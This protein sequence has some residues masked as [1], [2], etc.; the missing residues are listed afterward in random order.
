MFRILSISGGGY[1]GLFPAALLDAIEQD[2]QRPLRERFGL[3]AGT[4]IGGIIALGLAAGIPASRI[5]NGF[6][7]H[8]PAA[9]AGRAGGLWSPTTLY[10]L[11]RSARYDGHGLR[12]A[13]GSFIDPDMRM[14][15][16]GC[17]VVIP[18]VRLRD[19]YPVLIGRKSHPNLKV[20]DVALAASAAPTFFPAVQLG[21]AL[22]CDG[23]TFANSPDLLALH[24]ARD[25][26][27]W[28]REEQVMLSMGSMT[29]SFHIAEPR[30]PAMGIAAWMRG[31]R[32]QRT[33]LST[34][35][36][37]VRDLMSGCLGGRYL[38]LDA[39]AGP[40]QIHLGLDAATPRATAILLARARETWTRSADAVHQLLREPG[41]SSC[42]H[43]IL[44]ARSA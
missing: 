15:D 39:E 10:R 41:I 35:Q 17:D 25:R 26:F 5:V 36:I 12:R 9:F 40:D 27:G 30:D 13:I 7:I 37:L 32:L 11:M 44:M 42:D 14:A 4:S 16:L 8:G 23:A 31:E 29:A 6:V 38:R 34:Q 1:M 22:Y 2:G 21:D 3:I 20:I 18:V 28:R 33:V 24:E 43:P 19:G